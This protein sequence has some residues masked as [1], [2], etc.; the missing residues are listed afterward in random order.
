M[1]LSK[2]VVDMYII[3]FEQLDNTC[4][5]NKI[6]GEY[7]QKKFKIP[8]LSIKENGNFIFSNTDEFSLAIQ[9]LPVYLRIFK[10]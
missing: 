4:E 2:L 1:R 7:I 8:P 3:N 10:N 6:I 5:I 9:N